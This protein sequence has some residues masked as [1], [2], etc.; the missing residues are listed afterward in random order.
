[1]YRYIKSQF[2]LASLHAPCS[3]PSRVCLNTLFRKV[4]SVSLSHWHNVHSSVTNIEIID[5]FLPELA[6]YYQQSIN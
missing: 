6:S 5:T 3:I 1:M 4:Y 2:T